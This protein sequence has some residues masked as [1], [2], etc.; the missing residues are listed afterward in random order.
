MATGSRTL[1]LSILA[2]VDQLNKS[3]KAANGDVE[4]SSNKMMDFGK[5][6]GLAFAA[7]A[8]AAGAYAIKIGI[9]GVKAAIADEASQS[10]LAQTLGS[11]TGA[12]NQQ[13]TAVEKQITKLQLATGVADDVLRPAL[14]RLAISTG[15]ITKAQDLLALSLDV[16][17]ATGKPLETVANA[18]GKAY[19]GNTT[20]L[21]KLGV[22]LSAAELKTMSFTEQQQALTDLFGGAAAKNAETFQ[23]RMDR[24]TQ[25]VN[26]GKESIG[27]ALLPIL[28]KL[29]GYF[30]QYVLPIVEKI[31]NS[32]SGDKSG[33]SEGI[34]NL[35]NTIQR[36]FIPIWD[37]LVKAFG[38]VKDAIGDNMDS[39][40]AFGKL[41]AEYVA[42][43]IGTVLGKALEIVGK[44]A[45]GVINVIGDIIGAITAAVQGAISLINW[46]ISKYNS[47]PL[48]PNI[49][50]I[51][52]GG[53]PDVSI[54]KVS[55]SGSVGSTSLPSVPVPSGAGSVPSSVG[56]SAGAAS[57][58]ASGISSN[59]GVGGI[60]GYA[61]ALAAMGA[62]AAGAGGQGFGTN[63][64][65]V[66]VY[67]GVVGD[68]EA[69]A[70]VIVDT[71]NNSSYRGTGGANNFV[72]VS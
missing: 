62:G 9:D 12:T 70:R 65:G 39:F 31:S 50:L 61:Q 58:A 2:D 59:I 46:L 63:S 47:I 45:G 69:A 24:L 41:I 71:V 60:S 44:I 37:G 49:P 22:G 32:F 5:K 10:K 34:I 25:T 66:N 30:T 64:G 36:I 1:K 21:G 4:D 17:T 26:E 55:S 54:P 23:G 11:V 51:P 19:D 28:E 67:M 72:L 56:S 3:L 8:A 57:T 43:V 29:V 53:A 40:M 6:A 20:A 7:A 42:P 18:I 33:M 15:D 14:S 52:T 16:A 48:L 38:Y 35:G 68:P 13:I 27:Y